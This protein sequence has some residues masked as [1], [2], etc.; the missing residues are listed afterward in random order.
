ML[1]IHPGE[2]VALAG[3]KQTILGSSYYSWLAAV[4]QKVNTLVAMTWLCD[5]AV[6]V[7]GTKCLAGDHDHHL[8]Y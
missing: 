2:V 3:K 7:S 4:R 1:D 5:S 6:E 8:K